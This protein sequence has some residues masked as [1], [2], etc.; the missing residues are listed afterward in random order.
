VRKQALIRGQAIACALGDDLETVVAAARAMRP[1]VVRLPLV[2]AGMEEDR[3][4]FLLARR[5][6][7]A[8][9]GEAEPFFYGVLFDTVG[10]ALADAALTA[11]EIRETAIFLGST[12]IDVPVYEQA[13]EQRLRETSAET[14]M[15]SSGYGKIA[16]EV[17]RRFG[18][19]GPA[20]T[21]TT[22]CTSSANALLYAAGMIAAGRIRRALVIGYDLF[23]H[24]G[25]YGFESLRLIAT[26]A[27]RPFDR[28]RSGIVMGEGCGAVVLEAD[29]E[30]PRGV[31]LWGGANRVDAFNVTT[32]ALEGDAIAGVMR[33]ALGDAD[34]DPE[35]VTAIKAH[36]TGSENNDRMEGNGMKKVFGDRVPPFT[37]LKPLIGHTVGASGVVELILFTACLRRGFCPPTL[38]FEEADEELSLHP[39][40]TPEP[41]THGVFLLHYFG[42]GGNCTSL[43]VAVKG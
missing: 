28:R 10:R 24:L 16:D 35:A 21:F 18:I 38:G 2:L 37:V 5:E 32:H 12:S 3:P 14:V 9:N 29:A 6:G 11:A 26:D 19:R 41:M 20:Y 42:F 22:A 8:L 31:V 39:V 17:A 27:Y 25:F 30:T 33:D 34:V 7:G 4:Y 36:G 15:V 1:K 40:R 43:V 13:Y 23:S